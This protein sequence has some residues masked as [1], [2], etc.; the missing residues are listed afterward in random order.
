MRAWGDA[1]RIGP[2]ADTLI[3]VVL[4]S[5]RHSEQSCFLNR[6]GSPLDWLVCRNKTL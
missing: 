6:E 2:D 3:D 4:R 5:R 1:A